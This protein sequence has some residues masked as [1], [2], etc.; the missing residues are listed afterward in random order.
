MAARIEWEKEWID[1]VGA[2][3]KKEIKASTPTQF[4]QKAEATKLSNIGKNNPALLNAL[5]GL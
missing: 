5:K 3:T 2:S 1:K 4:K